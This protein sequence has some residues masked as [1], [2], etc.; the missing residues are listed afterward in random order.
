MT[1]PICRAEE[2]AHEAFASVEMIRVAAHTGEASDEAISD[3]AWAAA[4][5]LREIVAQL[6]SVPMA[7]RTV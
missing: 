1:N 4:D 7:R 2:M 5:L 3:A 6:E